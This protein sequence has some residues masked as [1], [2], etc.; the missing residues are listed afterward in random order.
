MSVGRKHQVADALRAR[1]QGAAHPVQA[2][3]A[4]IGRRYAEG[5]GGDCCRCPIRWTQLFAKFGQLNNS[6]ALFFWVLA[7]CW[8][9]V[10]PCERIAS[11]SSRSLSGKMTIVRANGRL[12][13]KAL[14]DIISPCLPRIAPSFNSIQISHSAGIVARP[15]P[16]RASSCRTRRSNRVI[17]L[18]RSPQNT[19]WLPSARG[20][21]RGARSR[22]FRPPSA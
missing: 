3:A 14:R 11:K 20:R 9:P 13:S 1:S 2:T 16:A 4:R 12:C 10:S 19:G 17:S 7:D 18:A 8:A 5:H 6:S 22:R 15:P 21:Q